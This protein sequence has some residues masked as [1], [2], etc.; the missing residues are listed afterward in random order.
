M[1]R[2]KFLKAFGLLGFLGILPMSG[3]EPA[4]TEFVSDELYVGNYDWDYSTAKPL[5]FYDDNLVIE[6]AT[7][8]L[9]VGDEWV[10]LEDFS[11]HGNEFKVGE[12]VV[13]IDQHGIRISN[14]Y[15]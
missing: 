10:R 3:K 8:D 5:Y 12:E 7:V 2:R 13:T 11:I 15:G 9:F 1:N 4:K 14:R 6:F